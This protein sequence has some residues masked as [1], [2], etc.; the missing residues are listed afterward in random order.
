MADVWV[1]RQLAGQEN[2]EEA[3]HDV[4]RVWTVGAAEGMERGNRSELSRRWTVWELEER[5]SRGQEGGRTGKH[6]GF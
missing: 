1:G 2:N 5:D 6:P 4:R 3:E